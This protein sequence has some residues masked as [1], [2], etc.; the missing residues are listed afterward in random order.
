M[1]NFRWSSMRSRLLGV[2]CSAWWDSEIS[3]HVWNIRY[4]IVVGCFSL[5]SWMVMSLW[6]LLRL[7]V[8]VW[9]CVKGGQVCCCGFGGEIRSRCGFQCQ[10]LRW[11]MLG[12]FQVAGW[13]EQ[14]NCFTSGWDGTISPS[15][16]HRSSWHWKL[17][18]LQISPPNHN[19]RPAHSSHITTPATHTLSSATT[20]TRT[21][22][23]K[24][25]KKTSNHNHIT[26]VPHMGWNLQISSSWKL[27]T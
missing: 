2:E 11:Y 15:T 16:Y 25:T 14:H 1:V 6:G 8:C 7:I 9:R 18:L 10:E 24:R 12:E 23:C 27:Y 5:S 3:A 21:S 20:P 26:Y 17:H 19:N 13:C 4:V 22:P